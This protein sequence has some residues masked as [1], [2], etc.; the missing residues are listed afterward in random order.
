MVDFEAL[1]RKLRPCKCGGH[2]KLIPL[3]CGYDTFD[4]MCEKCGGVWH[5]N[6]YSPIEAVEMWGV[7]TESYD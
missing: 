2:V 1:N 6:T 7:K 4:I 5:M 3:G